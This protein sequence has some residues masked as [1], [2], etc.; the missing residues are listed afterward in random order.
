MRY[1]AK[2]GIT[3]MLVDTNKKF[4]QYFHTFL[5]SNLPWN[6][7]FEENGAHALLTAEKKPVH[8][9]LMETKLTPAADGIKTLQNIRNNELLA[10]IPVV[11][12]SAMRDKGTIAR[13]RA[14]GMDE[15]FHKP[16][17]EDA[18]LESVIKHITNTVKF[19]VL[20][21]DSDEKIFPVVKD[22][23]TRNFPYKI[24]VVTATSAFTGMEIID[25]QEI[26]LLIVGNNLPVVNGVRMLNMLRDK[27]QLARLPVVF[28]PDDEIELEDRYQIA[29]LGIEHFA[30]KPFHSHALIESMMAALNVPPIPMSE[31]DSFLI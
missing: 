19:K 30:E 3:I 25:T 7:I 13:A 11:F 20:V 17:R 18:I 4:L 28:V 21:V 8:M 10:K 12:V 24:E 22:I 27:N 15:Y 16:I 5:K 2:S 6:F 1:D 26:N 31:E 14:A 29:E 9:F 23:I